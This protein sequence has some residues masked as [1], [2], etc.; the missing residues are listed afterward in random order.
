ML[1]F[2]FTE[3]G[4]A[5]LSSVLNSDRAINVNIQIMRAFTQ[6]TKIITSND[7]IRKKISE[8]ETIINTKFKSTDDKIEMIINV[9]NMLLNPGYEHI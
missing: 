1:P 2:A 3:Q 9:L 5:M 8:L 7:D 4:V 6:L